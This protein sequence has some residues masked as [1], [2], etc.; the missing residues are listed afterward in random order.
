MSTIAIVKEK[1]LHFI[2]KQYHGKHYSRFP[3][4]DNISPFDP[5]VNMDD[6]FKSFGIRPFSAE[7]ENAPEIKVDLTENDKAILFAQ[8]PGAKK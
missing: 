6:W 2:K 3:L 1:F 8:I 5:F 4:F 7:F